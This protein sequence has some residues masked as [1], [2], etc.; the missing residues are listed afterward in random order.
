MDHEF[1]VMQGELY[2]TQTR[3]MQGEHEFSLKKLLDEQPT[4]FTFNGTL[5][6]LIKTYKMEAK[7]GDMVRIFFGVGGSNATSSFDVISEIFDAPT[8]MEI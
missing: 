3:G 2:T 4:H 7:V 6:A 1:C 8:T 5:G